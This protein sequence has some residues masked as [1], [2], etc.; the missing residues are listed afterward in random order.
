TVRFAFFLIFGSLSKFASKGSGQGFLHFFE[1]MRLNRMCTD[2]EKVTIR[3][4][5]N[6]KSECQLHLAK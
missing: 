6:N 5:E 2:T 4:C 1:E 3:I